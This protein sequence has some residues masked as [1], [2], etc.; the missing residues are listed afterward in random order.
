MIA[1]C[2]KWLMIA[3]LSAGIAGAAQAQDLDIGKFHGLAETIGESIRYPIRTLRDR[4]QTAPCIGASA[5]VTLSA[6]G[7]TRPRPDRPQAAAGIYAS[8]GTAAV[9]AFAESLGAALG[10]YMMAL[11]QSTAARRAGPAEVART[12]ELCGGRHRGEP[13]STRSE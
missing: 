7:F 10:D 11:N 3:G 12:D 6:V 8:G 13:R 5:A 4:D 9:P 2:L 1:S